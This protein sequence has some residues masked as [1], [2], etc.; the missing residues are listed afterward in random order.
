M[1]KDISHGVGGSHD[2]AATAPPSPTVVP[3]SDDRCEDT[4]V[5]PS[6]P[7]SAR[8]VRAT[9]TILTGNH[10]GRVLAVDPRGEVIGRGV[11]AS[12]VVEDDGVSRRHARVARNS[13]G[14]FYVEDLASTN[15]TFVGSRRV[16]VSLLHGGETIQLGPDLQIRFGMVDVAEES[17]HRG[18]YE[19]SVRDPLTHL[20]NRKYLSDRLITEVARARRDAGELA[21][22]VADV[23]SLRRVNDRFGHLAG[24]RALCIVGAR[25]QRAVRVEDVLAR[26]GDDEF[27][28]VSVG[29]TGVAALQLGER[30]RRAIEELHVSARGQTVQITLSIGVASLAEI[31]ESD[32]PIAA[33]LTLA[34]TRLNGARA[35]GRNRVGA[36]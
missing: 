34:D 29:T 23:D 35:A 8:I 28:V 20:F 31:G 33:L 5:L 14:G 2:V 27:V 4:P 12:L 15:G 25:M 7:R 16:G 19:S 30:L 21:L 13:D 26:C 24:D 1:Q 6:R 22:L 11:D 3:A 17:L 32:E 10:A 9:L 36:A 18:L